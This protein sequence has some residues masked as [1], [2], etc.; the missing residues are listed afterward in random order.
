MLK[1]SVLFHSKLVDPAAHLSHSFAKTFRTP[2]SQDRQNFGQ[3]ANRDLGG[4]SA[5]ISSPIGAWTPAERRLLHPVRDRPF[6]GASCIRISENL[7]NPSRSISGS[8]GREFQHST[9][10]NRPGKPRER[11]AA[12]RSRLRTFADAVFR[13]FRV[14]S[15]QV[16]Q[17]RSSLPT[18]AQSG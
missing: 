6:P 8:R 1:R 5:P 12:P 11:N 14:G 9:R 18:P 7:R 2:F 13:R 4:E 10:S 3:H 15:R 17:P 16:P